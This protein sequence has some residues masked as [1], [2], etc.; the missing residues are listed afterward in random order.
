M[1]NKRLVSAIVAAGVVAAGVS[2]G[3]AWAGGPGGTVQEDIAEAVGTGVFDGEL[4]GFLATGATVEQASANVI[5]AC[6]A[7]GGSECT[8]DEATNDNLCIVSVAD[9]DSDVV[10]GG[11]GVNVEAA[12]I[13]ALARAAG[14]NTPIAADA[15]VVISDCP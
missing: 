4:V 3:T 9:D 12:R 14:N 6:Q 1:A 5:A 2:I 10:A 11:A 13:D 7:A 15:P 8:A